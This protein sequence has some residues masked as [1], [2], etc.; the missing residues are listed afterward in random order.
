M[1]PVTEK[2]AGSVIAFGGLPQAAISSSRIKFD[3]K[4]S[5]KELTEKIQS[6]AK[7][8]REAAFHLSEDAAEHIHNQ[9]P[10]LFADNTLAWL[11]VEYT[12]RAIA[13]R[14]KPDDSTALGKATD[15]YKRIQSF[16]ESKGKK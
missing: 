3:P 9:G 4:W 1:G 12:F 16:D 11:K 2:Q 14:C 8:D 15:L 6:L 7:T 5:S 10:K 13:C